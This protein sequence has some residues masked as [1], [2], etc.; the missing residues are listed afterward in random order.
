MKSQNNFDYILLRL[1]YA[2]K[3]LKEEKNTTLIL[4]AGCSLNSSDRDISTVGI[5]KQCL[6]EHNVKG[7]DETNWYDLYSNFVN[8]VWEGKS[9]KE[10]RK[11][12]QK[13]LEGVVPSEGHKFLRKLIELGYINNIITTN[14]DMLIEDVCDGLTYNKKV[15]EN[16]Y[17]KIGDGSPV[18]NLIKAHG[19][20]ETG[21]LKF[22]PAELTSLSQE[23]SDE[24]YSKTSGLTIFVGYRGQD[25][26]LMNSINKTDKASSVY[27]IDVKEP[28]EADPFETQQ[29]YSLLEKRGSRNNILYGS[30]YGDFNKVMEKIFSLLIP[31]ESSK[32]NNFHQTETGDIW[33]NTSIIDMLS[34]YARLLEL[35]QQALYFSEKAYNKLKINDKEY[36][37]EKYASYL[38][39]YLYFFKNDKL[40]S[41]LINIPNNEVDALVLGISI[42]IIV[43]SICSGIS[44]KE[45]SSK[46]KEELCKESDVGVLSDESFWIAVDNIASFDKPTEE[47]IQLH[48]NNNLIIQSVDVPL[49]ELNELINVVQLLSLILLPTNYN[50][51][52]NQR[53]LS[54]IIYGKQDSIENSDGKLHINLG[55]LENY[56]VFLANPMVCSL[57]DVKKITNDNTHIEINSKWVNFTFEIKEESSSNKEAD[58]S[59]YTTCIKRCFT[60]SKQF[61]D[62]GSTTQVRAH[63]KLELDTELRKFFASDRQAMFITGSSGSGKTTAIQNYICNNKNSEQT[64]IIAI[65]PKNTLINSFGISLFLNINVDESNEEHILSAINES[66]KIRDSKLILVFDGLNELN[67]SL[68]IQQ[69]HYVA[70]VD[71]AEKLYKLNCEHIK[72]I[73]T[74]RQWSYHLYKSNTRTQLNHLYFYSNNKSETNLAENQDA[75]YKIGSFK[76]DDVEKLVRCYLPDKHQDELLKFIKNQSLLYEISPLLIAIIGDYLTDEKDVQK[77]INKQSIYELFSAALFER[78]SMTNEFLAKKILYSYFELKLEYRNTN[79]DVTK[80]MLQNKLYCESNN[81]IVNNLDIVLNELA[82]VNILVKDLSRTERIR[83]KHDKIEECFFK[84]YIEEY[85]FQGIELFRKIFSLCRKN[86]IYQSGLIQYLTDLVHVDISEFKD[87][88]ISLSLENMDTLPKYVVEALSQSKDLSEDLRYLLHEKDVINS[89]KFINIL[90]LGFD[91]SLLAYSLITYDLKRV[92]DCLLSFTNNRIIT[93]DI[94]AYL[95]YFV[96]RLYYFTNDYASALNHANIALELINQTNAKLLTKI[97]M[98]K[99]VIFMEQGYSRSSIE[100]LSGEYKKYETSKDIENKMRVGIELG[101]ALNHSG[102]IEG[103]L[104]IYDTLLNENLED[105]NPYVLARIFEQKGNS[106]NKIMFTELNHGFTSKELLSRETI[107]KARD[108]FFEAVKLYE[109]S[110]ELL[111]KE[112]EVFCYGGVVPELINTYVGYSFSVE[113]YGIDECREL[114]REVDTLFEKIVT[115]YKADFYLAKAYFFEYLGE[116]EK[117]VACIKIALQSSVE[118]TNRNKEAKCCVFYSQFAYRRL[119]KL[120]TNIA[121]TVWR[122]LGLKYISQ[123]IN[124]YQ[125]HTVVENNVNLESCLALKEML[126]TWKSY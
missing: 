18:F 15:G 119:L 81:D 109:D 74:C 63:I 67:D 108:L 117:A 54:E 89:K 37:D 19:D 35:F 84:K 107:I 53:S 95:N 96:S 75:S 97:N 20:L 64:H 93:D 5:M 55:Q 104:L 49:K 113:P 62:L 125:T 6:R 16:E 17:I 11:L 44:T 123:S 24:I 36:T 92:I 52:E 12:L 88:I 121:S 32:N 102:Q 122:E 29:V 77:I 116:I 105:H 40:P 118:L 30:E 31:L 73:V 68:K 98:H 94:K 38:N 42:E 4:G 99:A 91:E 14:F 7:I 65:S 101:R 56:N 46:I 27:W 41:D 126:E 85:R 110:M 61:I 43:R 9:Q 25:V 111:L 2:F 70:L 87:T 13:R 10:R 48:F 76:N 1:L 106:L 83:F 39:S 8:I 82:D 80:F 33:K 100:I 120:D 47:A 71:L 28:S 57:P 79:I 58:E 22:A 45:Y 69:K 23:L 59:I 72:L 103:P 90:I 3:E 60:T 51:E 21:N 34:L 50:N 112:N 86:L 124:Y 26:G 66:F 115:P 114:I 78:I